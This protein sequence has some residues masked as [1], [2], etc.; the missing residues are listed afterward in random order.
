MTKTVLKVDGMSCPMCS[1]KVEKNL[2]EVSGVTSVAVDHKRGMAAVTHENVKDE[3]LIAAVL[4][5]GFRAKV[6]SGL[7]G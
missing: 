7:F 4:E 1:A 6:K 2:S 3:D 5:A